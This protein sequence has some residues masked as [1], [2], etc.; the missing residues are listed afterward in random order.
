MS[1]DGVYKK[2]KGYAQTLRS[3]GQF[4]NR[5]L[6]PSAHAERVYEIEVEKPLRGDEPDHFMSGLI[7]LRGEQ[8]PLRPARMEIIDAT[9]CR[10]V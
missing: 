9:H 5:I 1:Q 8:T 2:K 4:V 3:A 10:C 7:E 6:S